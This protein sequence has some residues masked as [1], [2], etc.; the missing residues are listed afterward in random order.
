MTPAS[1]GMFSRRLSCKEPPRSPKG[2]RIVL[3]E[4]LTVLGEHARSLGVP[5]LPEPLNRHEDHMVNTIEQVIELCRETQ[6][7]SVRVAAD[8]YHMNI[9]EMDPAASPLEAQGWLGHVQVSDSNRLEPGAGH[10]DWSTM[11]A[12]LDAARTTGGSPSRVA[13]PDPLSPAARHGQPAEASQSMTHARPYCT[14]ASQ[15]RCAGRRE[16]LRRCSRD[17]VAQLAWFVDGP[18]R[19]VAPAPA[20]LDSAFIAIGL[21]HISSRPGGARCSPGCLALSGA[22]RY[23]R[24]SSTQLPKDAVRSG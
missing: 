23:R 19:N 21:A 1:Y 20:E 4:A 12:A 3:L 8:T 5:D 24:S 10:I 22:T 7:P 2:D 9:E 13:C 15:S 6:L 17:T 14:C 16:H 11:L 18:D